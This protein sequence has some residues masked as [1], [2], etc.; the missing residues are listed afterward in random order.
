MLS[1]DNVEP[2]AQFIK[3]ILIESRE[4]LWDNLEFKTYILNV[5]VFQYDQALSI[6]RQ[7]L[8]LWKGILRRQIQAGK[9]KLMVLFFRLY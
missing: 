2:M 6:P 9:T 1:Y 5:I 3:Q 7:I 4:L 8:V